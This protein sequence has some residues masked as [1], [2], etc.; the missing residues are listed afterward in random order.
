MYNPQKKA[1]FW[2]HGI[3]FRLR[4]IANK[5]LK[6]PRA[7]VLSGTRSSPETSF[8]WHGGVPFSGCI[9]TFRTKH[10][11]RAFGQEVKSFDR[12]EKGHVTSHGAVHN[13]RLTK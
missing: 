7:L 1:F 9:A 4:D 12:L 11:S 8:G 13:G 2:N 10:V 5:P 3:R 6:G